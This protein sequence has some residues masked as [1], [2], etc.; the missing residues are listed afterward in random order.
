MCPLNMR[1]CAD[2]NHYFVRPGALGRL[3]AVKKAIHI[4]D[5]QLEKRYVGSAM[6]ERAGART[7]LTVPMLKD[8]EVI[9]AINIYRQEVRPFTD[10]QIELLSNF[11]AQAVIAIENTRLLNE[12]RESLHSRPRL[13]TCCVSSAPRLA[14]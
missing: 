2:S 6:L 13:P 4:P 12:L 14:A 10:N 7:L 5:V 9:G 3:P 8:G 11:A 1:K